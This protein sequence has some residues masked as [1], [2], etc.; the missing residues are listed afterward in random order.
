MDSIA[1]V[2]FNVSTRN[3][4][5]PAIGQLHRP[6]DGKEFGD[7]TYNTTSSAW[8]GFSPKYAAAVDAIASKDV[9]R[10]GDSNVQIRHIGERPGTLN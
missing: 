9:W 4:Y 6:N 8:A 1:P 5:I 2:L 10:A 7:R 3:A